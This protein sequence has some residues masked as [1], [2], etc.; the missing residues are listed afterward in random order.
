MCMIETWEGYCDFTRRSA[1]TARRKTHLCYECLRTIAIGER[2]VYDSQM[3]EGHLDRYITCWQCD[4]ARAWLLKHCRGWLFGGVVVDIEQHIEEHDEERSEREAFA[5]A[6]PAEA[7]VAEDRLLSHLARGM[8][9]QWRD[10][11]DPAIEAA[12]GHTV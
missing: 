2:Y 10:G 11:L 8:R 1:H 5:D 7:D 6:P 4:V 3:Y 12:V 9:Q